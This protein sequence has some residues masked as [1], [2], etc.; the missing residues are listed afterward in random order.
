MLYSPVSMH[1]PD[2]FLS[3][4][5]SVLFWAVSIIFIIIAIQK[6]KQQ[7]DD[8]QVPLMGILAAA[9]FAG[10]MLNFSEIG[11]AHV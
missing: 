11:R 5:V 4:I 1:I 6:T 7:L 9:I 2:G 10:Q 8:K 3:T